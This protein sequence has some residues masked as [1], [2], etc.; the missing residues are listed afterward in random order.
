[1]QAALAIVT[2]A[3]IVVYVALGLSAQLLTPGYDT[4]SMGASALAVGPH[5]RLMKAGFVARGAAALAL[6]A[7]LV[8]ALPR[9]A[10]SP[11]GEALIVVWGAGAIVLALFDTDMPGGPRTRHGAVHALVAA[12]AY[13]AVAVGELLVA[14]RFGGDPAWRPLAPWAVGL[15]IAVLV[16][17]VAQ[18][19]AFSAATRSMTQGLGRYGGLMQRVFLGLALGWMVVVALRV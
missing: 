1:M 9:G 2:V 11:V 17:L 12:L 15:A 19:A 5:G 8:L 7:A 10:R 16:A 3:A 13:I 14:L 18:F 6:V 4:L